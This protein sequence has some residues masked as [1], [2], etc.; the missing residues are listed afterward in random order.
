MLRLFTN[1]GF[2]VENQDVNL[3]KGAFSLNN[4]KLWEISPSENSKLIIV[5][6]ISNY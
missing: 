5:N 6:Y 1:Y 4:F 2:T 3:Y